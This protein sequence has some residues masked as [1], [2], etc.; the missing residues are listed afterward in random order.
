MMKSPL[1]S[2][3]S[4]G[5]FVVSGL[6]QPGC[7]VVGLLAQLPDPLGYLQGGQDHGAEGDEDG[8]DDQGV[9]EAE[10]QEP[11][12]VAAE[13]I[14]PAE[15]P[16]MFAPPK[17]TDWLVAALHAGITGSPKPMVTATPS[18]MRPIPTRTR[19][20]EAGCS[21]GVAG[22]SSVRAIGLRHA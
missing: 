12:G 4:R 22:R 15:R 7:G 20:R 6:S 9:D 1:G 19:M 8:P 17:M 21:P 3:G 13:R 10:A 16:L 14:T 18:T 2:S 5:D 11:V